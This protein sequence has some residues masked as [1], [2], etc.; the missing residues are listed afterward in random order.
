M[1]LYSELPIYK[2]GCDLL[3]L[4][5]DVQTQMPRIF[6]RSLGEKIHGLCVEM[7]EA[8]A[9]ANAS[10]GDGRVQQ[11]D[12]LLQHLRATTAML[13]VSHDKRL[14]SPKLWGQSVELLDTVGSMA[15]GWRKQTIA[16]LS[17]A[18]AA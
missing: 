15:G 2:H 1:A 17:A 7:L 11:L 8:M 4:A 12:L 10:R 18:P 3:S 9:M 13:R 16:T 6:K 5:L 14:I